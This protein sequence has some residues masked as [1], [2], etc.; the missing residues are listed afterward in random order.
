MTGKPGRRLI[1]LI[2]PIRARRP[3]AAAVLAGA[4]LAASGCAS[5]VDPIERLGRKAVER[6]GT[7]EPRDTATTAE[8]PAG[9]ALPEPPRPARP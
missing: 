6:V 2:R 5:A 8:R 7:A 4:L 3:V 1:G 9:R